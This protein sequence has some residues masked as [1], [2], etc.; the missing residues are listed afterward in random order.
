M[1]AG[2]TVATDKQGR[3]HC[4]TVV[5]GTFDIEPDGGARPADQQEELVYADAHYGDP[6]STSI[7][8]ECDFA[9]FKPST[10]VLLNGTATSPTRQPLSEL[11]VGLQ[12]GQAK[13]VIRVV[14]DR[15][16]DVGLAGMKPSSPSSFVTMPLVY[17]RAFGGSDSSHPNPAKHGADLRNPIGVGYRKNSEPR[18]ILGTALPNLEDPNN[19]IRAW[20]DAPTP[21]GFGVVGRGWQPRISHAGTYDERW[22]SERFPF[23]PTDFDDRYFLSAPTDQQAPFLKGGELIRCANVGPERILTFSLPTVDLPITFR[24]RDRD[25]TSVPTLDTVIIEPDQRRVI[26]IWR[27]SVP[28]GRKMNA[29]RE[30]TVG[31]VP[32]SRPRRWRRGKPMFDSLSDLAA[33]NRNKNRAPS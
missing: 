21:V 29:L 24:F 18:A 27:S 25:V 32:F 31:K 2:L 16:W 20:S 11:M 14:G 8:Y 6:A 1:R 7:K 26:V 33:W 3:N 30:I 23:L 22:L 4:V 12:L 13:K 17:E 28:L 10:D 9:L 19:P 5:K 15:H